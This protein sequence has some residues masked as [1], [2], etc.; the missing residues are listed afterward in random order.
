M[1]NAAELWIVRVE[2][3]DYGPADLRTLREWKEDGRVL[4]E[5]SARPS[6]G[7]NWIT[8]GEIA[9]LFERV[10]QA[11][12]IQTQRVAPRG[13]FGIC[14][15]TIR[16]YIRGFL[17]FFALTLL[18]V[19]PS[20]CAQL[21]GAFLE[22]SRTADV[23][24]RTMLSAGFA[25]CMALLTIAAWPIYVAGIQILAARLS[26]GQRIG[27]FPMLNEAIKFWPRVAL[28][29]LFVYG[30][31]FFWAAVPFA[32][33]FTIAL[34]GPSVISFFL[35]LLITGF[36]VWML[37]RLFVNFLF[38]PQSA[39]LADLNM[40][41][42]LR[43]SRMV[44]RSGRDLPWYERPLW[45][46]VFI[47]SLWC[48]FVLALNVPLIWPQMREYFHLLATTPDPQAL[49]QTLSAS[50]PH[51]FDPLSFAVSCVQAVLRPL[52][53]IAFVVLYLD[54]KPR[55]QQEHRGA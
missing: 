13:F 42:A 53:G 24:V 50:K 11:P 5:N 44:A 22:A 10:V 49:L 51:G 52:L 36:L 14:A 48:G 4:P 23:D 40:A 38:W 29:C 47:S 34:A 3:K 39:V 15:D 26:A 46:G 17:Q 16:I 45:R 28:L 27:F 1:S 43:D 41:E 6:E 33:I 12:P 19:V 31:F 21:T 37:G 20:L 54:A 2:G 32:L 8:A 7:D 55:A 18:V 25:M 30:S 9:G 35:V